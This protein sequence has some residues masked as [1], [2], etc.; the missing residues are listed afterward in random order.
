MTRVLCEEK[1]CVYYIFKKDED[2]RQHQCDNYEIEMEKHPGID[3]PVCNSFEKPPKN[4][5]AKR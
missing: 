3:K 5:S 4:E 1:R 2:G